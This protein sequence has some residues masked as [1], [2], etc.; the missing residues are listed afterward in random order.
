MTGRVW[1][2]VVI[3]SALMAAAVGYGYL[4]PGATTTLLSRHSEPAIHLPDRQ[5]A[6]TAEGKLFHDP[7]CRYIHGRPEMVR[8]Q[9]AVRRGYTPC[10]RCL[11]KA[12][13]R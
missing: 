7:S 13:Q 9:E 3:A 10:P 8:A 1:I 11:R 2:A 5:V 12:L 4:R 6:I